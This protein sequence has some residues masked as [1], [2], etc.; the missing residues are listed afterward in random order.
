MLRCLWAEYIRPVCSSLLLIG[1]FD[2]RNEFLQWIMKIQSFKGLDLSLSH[3]GTSSRM[4]VGHAPLAVLSY[5]DNVILDQTI[6]Q[7]SNGDLES[8]EYEGR[9][10]YLPGYA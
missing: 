6:I 9:L 8:K 5:N 7:A 2:A 1:H 3:T 4:L 10:V